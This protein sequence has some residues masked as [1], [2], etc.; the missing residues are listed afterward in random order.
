M[1]KGV[2]RKMIGSEANIE[3]A[4]HSRLR[5]LQKHPEKV[6]AFFRAEDTSYAA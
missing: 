3:R 4:A 1:N 2:G 6:R 5:L